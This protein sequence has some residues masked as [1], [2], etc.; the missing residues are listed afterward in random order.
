MNSDSTGTKG[1]AAPPAAKAKFTADTR[2]KTERRKKTDRR[3]EIRF[4]SGRRSD[5]DRRPRKGWTD[6][7]SP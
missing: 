5:K 7:K 3:D 4:E 2:D 1:R 6:G